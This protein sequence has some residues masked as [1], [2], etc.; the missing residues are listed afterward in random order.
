MDPKS[1]ETIYIFTKEGTLHK[2]NPN[3]AKVKPMLAEQMTSAR[4]QLGRQLVG[5]V[6]QADEVKLA[7]EE[8]EADLMRML[9]R[10]DKKLETM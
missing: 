10:L 5:A 8:R 9:A 3:L 2:V 4:Q 6:D 1:G 7:W